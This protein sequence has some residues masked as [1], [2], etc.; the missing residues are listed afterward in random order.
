MALLAMKVLRFHFMARN[1]L[2]GAASDKFSW[3]TY[4]NKTMEHRVND[5]IEVAW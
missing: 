2:L 3:A 5:M 1:E 4:A